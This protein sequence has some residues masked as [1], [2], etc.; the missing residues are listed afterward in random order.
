MSPALFNGPEPPATTKFDP[1]F[2]EIETLRAK[3][4]ERT[5]TMWALGGWGDTEGFGIVAKSE[6]SRALFANNVKS[7]LDATNTDGQLGILPSFGRSAF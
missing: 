4:A 3:F 2:T 7:L 1:F 5:K 6:E